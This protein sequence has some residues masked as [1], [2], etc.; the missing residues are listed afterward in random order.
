MLSYIPCT[1]S[2]RLSRDAVPTAHLSRYLC[3][4]LLFYTFIPLPILPNKPARARRAEEK[5]NG[6]SRP[7]RQ[8]VYMA[9]QLGGDPI[10]RRWYHRLSCRIPRPPL[11]VP[12]SQVNHSSTWSN[13]DSSRQGPYPPLQATHENILQGREK[14]QDVPHEPLYSHETQSRTSGKSC[15]LAI[16]VEENRG[17][18]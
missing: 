12:S 13:R 11:Q 17:T 6:L 7:C 5:V 18:E 15:R 3:L 16:N 14:H 8:K 4:P 10:Q 1:T 2:I 9:A